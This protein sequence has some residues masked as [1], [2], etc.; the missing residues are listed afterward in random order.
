[1][2]LLKSVLREISEGKRD[3]APSGDSPREVKDFQPIA[4]CLVYA[5]KNNLLRGMVA[6][7]SMRQVDRGS[8]I[9]ILLKGGLTLEG[10]RY[11]A[12]ESGD[13]LVKSMANNHYTFNNSQ[14]IQIGDGNSQ[15]FQISL[16]QLIKGIDAG[17]GS[18][19]QKKEAKNLLS[20][21]LEH[22]LVA[23]VV[24]AAASNLMN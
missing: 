23:A 2:E 21:F 4:K 20:K 14:G 18:D 15:Q 19:E 16:Q 12:G 17:P 9:R 6:Q 1:M 7:E 11:L 8:Y 13:L 22:P 5:N 10:D 3:Y 24:G